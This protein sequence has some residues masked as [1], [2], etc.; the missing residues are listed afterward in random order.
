MQRRPTRRGEARRRPFGADD[1]GLF[2][3]KVVRTR[4]ALA[5]G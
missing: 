3:G 5:K 4:C 2:R 1:G